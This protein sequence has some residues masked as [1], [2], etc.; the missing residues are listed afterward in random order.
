MSKK[1]RP[2][3]RRD[4]LK[5][6]AFGGALVG[7]QLYQGR[8][9]TRGTAPALDVVAL[10]RVTP[11]EAPR[12]VHFWATWCGVCHAMEHNIR[13]FDAGE[14]TMVASA[15]GSAPEVTSWL[16]AENKSLDGVVVDRGG[17][18]RTW[19]VSAYPTTFVV[20]QGEIR[21]V[22]IGYTTELGLRLRLALAA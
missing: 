21:D 17:S 16:N 4:F 12:L 14:V 10:S 1:S 15:S 2:F 8:G 18:A 13:A 19:G 7:I 20:S 9:S 6:V 5:G 22:C 3:P 11:T